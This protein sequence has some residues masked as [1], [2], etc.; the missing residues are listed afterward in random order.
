[1][2]LTNIIQRLKPLFIDETK[3]LSK[4]IVIQFPV[5]D[6]C[7]SKCQMCRIWENKK[8]NDITVEQ[9]RKGLQNSLF[10]DV[11]SI[12]FNGGE[13]TL[14]ED[15]KEIVGTCIA[16][17]PKLKQISLITNAY[18]YKQV[19]EQIDN[20][21]ELVSGKDIFFDVMVSLDGYGK[22]HDAVRG[23]SGNFA[24][25]Q[26]VI[27]HLKTC[28]FVNNI[29]IGCTVI[30]ENAYHLHDLLEFC[31]K[32]DI[33]IKYRQGVPHKRL[34]TEN[35]IE[36]YALTFEEKYEFVEFL[37]GLIEHY[38]PSLLQ[39]HFYRSLIG[40]IIHDAPRTAGCD[41]K[42]RGATITARGE[43]A[44]CAVESKALMS[45]ISEGD[46]ET[47]FFGNEDHLAE[48][49]KNKCDSC[50]HDYVGLPTPQQ[51]RKIFL[52]NINERFHIKE[53]IKKV[54][55]FS[56][57]NKAR[58]ISIYNKSLMG[59]RNI[60]IESNSVNLDKV[61][62][63]ICGWYGTETL[64]DKAIIAGIILSIRKVFGDNA[65]IHIA[66]LYPYITEMTSRQMPE[67]KN[68]RVITIEKAIQLSGQMTYVMFGGGP[69]MA[70]D[71]IAPMQVIFE[72]AK[73][74]QATT[75]VAGC[76]I[77]PLGDERFNDSIKNILSLSDKR[78]YRDQ[79][80]KEN[81]IYLGVDASNDIVAEDPAFTWL[82]AINN[83]FIKN[84]VEIEIT[85][86]GRAK[87]LLLGL[88]DFP[89]KEYAKHLSEEQAVSVKNNYEKTVVEALE[90]L[91]LQDDS[92]IIKPL[93]MCTNHFG[94]DDR[95]FYRKLFRDSSIQENNLD[96]S[97]CGRELEPVE[98]CK[99]FI[100]ADGLLA[101]RFHSFV[102]GLA[103]GLPSIALDYTLGRGKVKSLAEKY[104]STAI[105]LTDI[106]VDILLP[107]LTNLLSEKNGS[108]HNDI[109]ANLKFSNEMESILNHKS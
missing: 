57:A 36:P 63:L 52:N 58:N 102:F 7:N 41:W 48:I 108:P 74:G 68:C 60:A 61:N 35:L 11:E 76:G 86:A 16:M 42:H 30:K 24:N 100:K 21:G 80:S 18:K 66:S 51:Y 78:I 29:R 67:F 12:G 62:I 32:N 93:P 97:L 5:I 33:Y 53:K 92:I 59:Y 22:V 55:F 44:Y 45:N 72:N 81:A 19:I 47:A 83:D 107:E 88:R 28:S 65:V 84:Q 95:W 26:H 14:R 73:Q 49:V 56:Y 89:W 13:P 1:M 64:G 39:K 4:P 17:L 96:F 40:Q 46:A 27:S 37:E 34:Y 85:E 25:A 77:G 3:A 20:I 106:T 87:T 10:S 75:I 70:I 109:L 38:E 105:S 8:S 69:L 90:A 23:R 6:I 54:P 43:L 91:V 50:H 2:K 98:Y 9:L 101:M 82:K 94:S 79:K 15:L 99:E 103:L 31:I 71:S 104:N